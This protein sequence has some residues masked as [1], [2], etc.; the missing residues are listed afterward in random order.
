[1]EKGGWVYILSDQ[2]NNVLYTGVR[3]NLKSRIY[4]HK[5]KQHPTT[6]ISTYNVN[7]LVYFEFFSTI[8]EAIEMEKKIKGGS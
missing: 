4:E 3:A 8:I 2:Y 1:M 5:T 6:F 7:K